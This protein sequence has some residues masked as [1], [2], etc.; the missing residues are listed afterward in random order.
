MPRWS[1]SGCGDG[2]GCMWH[3]ASFEGRKEFAYDYMA[4]D[5]WRA[6]RASPSRR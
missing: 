3:Y 4:D 1:I 5:G 6:I 2:K